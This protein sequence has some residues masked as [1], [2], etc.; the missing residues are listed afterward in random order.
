MLGSNQHCACL[1]SL[2]V[3]AMSDTIL[4]PS[5]ENLRLRRSEVWFHDDGVSRTNVTLT[6]RYT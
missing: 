6:R 5:Y 3:V 1:D 4:P 2:W